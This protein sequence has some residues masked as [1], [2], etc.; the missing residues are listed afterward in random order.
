MRT[1]VSIKQRSHTTKRHFV[2]SLIHI[3][4]HRLQ[5]KYVTTSPDALVVTQVVHSHINDHLR[6]QYE[7]EI[8][9]CDLGVIVKSAFGDCSMEEAQIKTTK[10]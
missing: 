1:M 4:I 10:F 5:S 9:S 6:R 8:S 7:I 2:I 3:G